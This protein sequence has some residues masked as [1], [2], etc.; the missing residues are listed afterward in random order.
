MKQSVEIGRDG[1]SLFSAIG[2]YKRISSD[3]NELC[4]IGFLVKGGFS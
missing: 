2:R 1:L 3:I 4:K